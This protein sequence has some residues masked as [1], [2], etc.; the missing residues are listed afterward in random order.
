MRLHTAIGLPVVGFFVATFGTPVSVSAQPPVPSV[1]IVERSSVPAIVASGS[2]EV[3]IT[4]SLAYITLGVETRDADSARAS[5][6]NAGRMEQVMKVIRSLGVAE[7]DLQTVGYNIYQTN[8]TGAN[9]K[10]ERNF[11]VVTNSVRVT[12]RKL[13]DVGRIIDAA[14]QVGANVADGIRLDAEDAAKEQAYD[15]ALEKAVAAA[16]RKARTMARAGN[17]TLQR[18]VEVTEE[19]RDIAVP[20]PA[21]AMERFSKAET[22][23]AG[24]ELTVRANVTVRYAIGGTGL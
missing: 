15:E 24:G 23:I 1:S 11:Y 13:A 12:V 19:A 21:M 18:L 6:Q 4:P 20:M 22:P 5:T 7:K 9:G 2:G 8:Q 10:P 14:T 16:L 3:N 17:V